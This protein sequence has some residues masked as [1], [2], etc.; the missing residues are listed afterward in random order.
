V[1]SIQYKALSL[2]NQILAAWNTYDSK[3]STKDH[4]VRK[5]DYSTFTRQFSASSK[6]IAHLAEYYLQLLW[7][8]ADDATRQEMREMGS[9]LGMLLEL[10]RIEQTE[11][12]AQILAR[13][14]LENNKT[15]C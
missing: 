7:L 1:Q 2:A 8:Y 10:D 14:L 3:R 5:Q 11:E 13:S 4:K 6:N 12:R 15:L 9:E